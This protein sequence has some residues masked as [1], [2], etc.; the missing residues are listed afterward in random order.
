MKTILV[1]AVHCFV[2]PGEG[3][4]ETLHALLE[5]YPNEKVILTGANDEQM[6]KFGLT[7]VPYEVFTLKHDPEK[8]DPAYYTQL[9]AHRDLSA[10]EVVYFEHDT[11]AVASARSVGI[12]THH[13]NSD[14]RDLAALQEFLDMHL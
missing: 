8:T 10:E 2:H 7:S 5:Q 14:A 12:E 3:V 6:E 4:D 1:D 13:Y 11:A 9:L